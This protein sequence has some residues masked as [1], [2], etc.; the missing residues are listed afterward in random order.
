MVPMRTENALRPPILEPTFRCVKCIITIDM[1]WGA[2]TMRSIQAACFQYWDHAP[3][4]LQ[5]RSCVMASRF[6]SRH[7]APEIF[8]RFCRT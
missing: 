5:T 2:I 1:G 6:C 8:S 3:L 4:A 7:H